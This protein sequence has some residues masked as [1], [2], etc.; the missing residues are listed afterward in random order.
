MGDAVLVTGGSGFV[1]GWCIVE[2]LKNGHTVRASVRDP[3]RAVSVRDAVSRVVDPGDRLRFVTADLLSDE[4]WDEAVAGCQYV[5]HVASPLTATRDEEQVIRPAV[6]GVRR[7]LRAC[8]DAGVRRV[9]YTSSCG[10][11]YYGHPPRNGPFDE[12]DWTNLGTGKMSAYVK[13]KALAERAAWNF[14]QDEGDGLELTAVNPTGI[15]GPALSADATSS[16]GLI[17][18]LLDGIPAC[19]D[20]WFCV[21]DVRDVADLHL[22]AMT[23]PASG[24]RY[25]ANA[26]DPVSMLTIARELRERLGQAASRVPTRKMPDL[27]VRL[28]GRFNAQMND[29]VPLLGQQRNASAAKAE[30]ELGWQGRPWQDAVVASAQSLIDLDLVAH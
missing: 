11:V 29:L 26:S 15:F 14:I 22:R 5:L 13:S 27:V 7:V 8:R 10:A 17:K 24:Q 23:A 21:A 30:R 9:V 19:P 25:I 20:L 16:L 28:I 12:S 3:R 18:R 6:D 1:A 4:N 2:L